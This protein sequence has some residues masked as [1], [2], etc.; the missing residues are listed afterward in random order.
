MSLDTASA[1]TPDSPSRSKRLWTLLHGHD[2][3][4]AEIQS[5]TSGV[6]LRVRYNLAVMLEFHNA[7]AEVTMREACALRRRFETLGWLRSDVW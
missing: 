5:T 1:G 7:S 3:A 4:S 2:K 6:V